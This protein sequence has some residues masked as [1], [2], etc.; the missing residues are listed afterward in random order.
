MALFLMIFGIAIFVLFLTG[1]YVLASLYFSTMTWNTMTGNSAAKLSTFFQWPS[2]ENAGSF[3]TIVAAIGLIGLMFGLTF[4]FM[5]K[6]YQK[7]D[8]VEY[9][10]RRAMRKLSRGEE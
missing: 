1:G 5:G 8:S 6:L 9:V 2:A 4:F 10:S 3:F 7:M